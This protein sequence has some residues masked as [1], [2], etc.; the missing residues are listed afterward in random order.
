[1]SWLP[2]VFA[3]VFAIMCIIHASDRWLLYQDILMPPST[4]RDIPSTP[5]KLVCLIFDCLEKLIECRKPRLTRALLAFLFTATSKPYFDDLCTTVGLVSADG[6]GRLNQ[7]TL[8]SD[9]GEEAQELTYEHTTFNSGDLPSFIPRVLAET[10][11]R[12][13]RSL[14]LLRA[15]CPEHP[16]LR[17]HDQTG[18]I[19]WGWTDTDVQALL[20]GDPDMHV[21]PAAASAASSSEHVSYKAELSGFSVFDLDPDIHYQS[22]L[23]LASVETLSNFVATFPEELPSTTPTLTDVIELALRPLI[24]H[25]TTLSKALVSVYLSPKSHLHLYTHLTILRSYLLLTSDAFHG[26]LRTALFSDSPKPSTPMGAGSLRRRRF[27]IGGESDMGTNTRPTWVIGLATGLVE[28]ETWPPGGSDLSFYLRTV[29]VDT[30]PL[31]AA[32]ALKIRGEGVEQVW[33]EAENR[34]GFALR[35]LPVHTGKE[36]WLNPLALE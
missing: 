24:L 13:Q 32:E 25:T 8:P 31:S 23:H 26:R 29:I 12:A 27:R 2:F 20:D 11:P 28:N 7:P 19:R 34:V 1:M 6:A 36:K 10:I 4:Y 5:E 35:E 18:A 3:Y 17:L 16:L 14:V 15:A 21:P 30:I 22:K 9:R 33:R